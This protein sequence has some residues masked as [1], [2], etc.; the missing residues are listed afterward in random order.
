MI[1]HGVLSLATTAIEYVLF[2]TM[3]HTVVLYTNV[4]LGAS[5]TLRPW[6]LR[7]VISATLIVVSL[8]LVANSTEVKGDRI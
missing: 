8:G 2:F 3:L 4:K 7:Q 1:K 6:L 5:K